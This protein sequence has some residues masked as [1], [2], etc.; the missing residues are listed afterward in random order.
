[1]LLRADTSPNPHSKHCDMPVALLN[2][3]A[4]QREPEKSSPRSEQEEPIGQGV[5]AMV[6]VPG[7]YDPKL[8]NVGLVLAMVGQ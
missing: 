7:Q 3:P 4:L 5:G 6:P 1:V 8:H 2:V